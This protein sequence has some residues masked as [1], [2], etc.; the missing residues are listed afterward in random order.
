MSVIYTNQLQVLIDCTLW[1]RIFKRQSLDLA[2]LP[3]VAAQRWVWF[4]DNWPT[5]YPKFKALSAGNG[6]YEASLKDFD[7]AV[8]S[9]K[10][11]NGLNPL[12]S[13]AKIADF[14]FFLSVTGTESLVLTPDE[15]VLVGL[16]RQRVSKFSIETFLDMM[17]FLRED[18]AARAGFVGLGDADAARIIGVQVTQRQRNATVSDLDLMGDVNQFYKFVESIAYLY[19]RSVNKPPNLLAIAN[20][21]VSSDS[22]VGFSTA[23]LSYFP[24]P[25]EISLESMA[26]KYLGDARR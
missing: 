7:A 26:K 23:Y 17:R 13:S 16:E 25:F 14:W 24:M 10:L 11:G 15:Q 6:T 18:A 4:V 20:N 2:I 1:L 8:R 19:K 22:N 21:N 9:Y 3:S 12:Q 5:I